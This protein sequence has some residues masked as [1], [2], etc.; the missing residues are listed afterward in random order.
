[1]AVFISGVRTFELLPEDEHAERVT[2]NRTVLRREGWNIP[3][4][5]VPADPRSLRSLARDR[6]MPR[7]LFVKSPLERKPMYLD[8]ES[9]SLV[10]VL[11]RHARHAAVQAP[12]AVIRFREMLPS[13]EE[14]WLSD[15]E[16]NRYVSELRL[17]AVAQTRYGCTAAGGLRDVSSGCPPS[18]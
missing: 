11:G 15:G 17:V 2:V 12:G 18:H 13:P 16:G 9:P 4:D 5:A 3:A 1:M 7:R 10:R 14:C 8:V 6:G